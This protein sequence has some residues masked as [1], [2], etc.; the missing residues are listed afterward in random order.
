MGAA[1]VISFEEVRARKQWDALR[2]RLHT[3][4]DQWLDALEAQ[5]QEPLPS[6]AQVTETVLNL[7]QSLTGGLTETIVKHAHRGEHTRQQ[8]NCPPCARH[9]KARPPV[10]RT[11]ESLVWL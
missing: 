8:S 4:F 7:R 6:L 3:R 11:V 10:Q 1:E 9:L 5:L 2:G